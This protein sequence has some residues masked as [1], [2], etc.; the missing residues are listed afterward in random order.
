MRCLAGGRRLVEQA[1]ARYHAG[2]VM[3]NI[4]SS[5]LDIERAFVIG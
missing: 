2:K 5:R 1:F 4:C 3:A